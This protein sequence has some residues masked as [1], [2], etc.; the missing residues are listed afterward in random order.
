[1]RSLSVIRAPKELLIED[2]GR[3]GF[4]RYGVT[5]AGACDRG[6]LKLANRLVGNPEGAPALEMLL[7]PAEFLCHDN[8]IFASTGA[9]LKLEVDGVQ[10]PQ[11]C[12]INVKAGSKLET[13]MP[14]CGV[15]SYLALHGGVFV[16]PVL[17]SSSYDT[18]GQIGPKPLRSGDLVVVGPP[19]TFIPSELTVAP[20]SELASH[21]TLRG[22]WGPRVSWFSANSVAKLQTISLR[23]TERANRVGVCLQG[24]DLVRTRNDE[25]P[26]EGVLRGSIQVTPAGDTI[27]FLADHPVTGGYPTL[28]VLDTWSCDRA[29]QL[30]PGDTLRLQLRQY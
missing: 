22:W 6:S 2:L 21:P 11:N 27:L 9:K 5:E 13:S 12:A 3:H 4:G 28:G 8:L 1:M 14:S 25:L 19:T 23:V 29:A 16:E 30:R 17:G 20:V 15:R 7:G 26:P 24:G 18:L 10:Q